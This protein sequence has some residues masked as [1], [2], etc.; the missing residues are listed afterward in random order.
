MILKRQTKPGSGFLTKKYDIERFEIMFK[1]SPIAIWEEDF[2]ALV[3]LRAILEKEN[4]SH[5]RSYLCEHPKLVEQTFR[6]LK[7]VDVNQAA[8]ELY[9]ASSKK[10][11]IENLGKRIHHE[12]L[13]VMVDEFASLLEGR[14]I[15]EAEFKSRTLGG[16]LYDVIMRV[17]VP[18]V[19]KKNFKRV[20][21]T[22]QDISVQ[23][24][25]ERHL[26]RLAQTDGLTKILNH[27]AVRYRLE[28]EF[29]RAKRY[30][31]NLS[32]MMID[33]DHFKKINDTH[34]HQKGDMVLRQTAGLIKD[35]LRDVDVVG[36]YG[37][38]EFLVILPETP[39]ERAK[40]AA[41]RI[42]DLFRSL[43][44]QTDK[45]VFNTVSIGISGFSSKGVTTAKELMAKADEALYRAKEAGRNDIVVL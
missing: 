13:N 31:L 5:I 2:S 23:K 28:E 22:F 6:S 7:V 12:A 10:E 45:G 4:V 9:G 36:R 20:I 19:Y 43:T 18:E 17:S 15:F 33:M 30:H 41:Q 16:R 24:K 1:Y 40:I 38:D 8:L 37:G 39:A 27:N 34:G 25:Y 14:T 32:C 35:N 26:Q 11:L 42:I 44:R 29:L 3:K 21:V